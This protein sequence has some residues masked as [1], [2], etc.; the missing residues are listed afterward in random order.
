MEFIQVIYTGYYLFA[1]IIASFILKAF[2]KGTDVGKKLGTAMLFNLFMILAY[3]LNLQWEMDL[4]KSF[5]C[6][7]TFIMMDLMLLFYYD[8][9]LVFIDAHQKAKM[10]VKVLIVAYTFV[11]AVFMLINPFSEIALSYAHA[12]I[13]ESY[14]LK[15][16]PAMP[17]HIHVAFNI[18]IIVLTIVLLVL[19]CSDAP[20]I[21]SKR[22][23][24]PIFGMLLS[25]IVYIAYL[26]GL[27]PFDVDPTPLLYVVVGLSL[28]FY[29]FNY[30]PSVTMAITRNMILEYL[31]D[32][33]ILFDY[34]GHLVDYSAVMQ[35]LLPDVF[36][37]KGELTIE[38]F[39]SDCN[40]SG[41]GDA[42]HNQEFD[43]AH[44]EHGKT[45]IYQCQFGLLR[46]NENKLI[47]KLFVFHDETNAR[48]TFFELENSML[49]DTVTGLYNKQSFYTQIPQWNN[50]EYWPV[51][52]VVCNVDGLRAMNEAYGT[53][54]G[55][56]VMRQIAS[57]IR[58][59]VGEETFCAKMDNGD[60]VII[61]EKT[62]NAD[63][64]DIMEAVKGEVHDFYERMPV[65]V[66]FGIATKE[67]NEMT[68][69]KA[70]Q[71]A[72]TSMQNKKMLK[73]KSASSS[74]IDSL[75]QTLAES[76]DNTEEHVERTREMCGRLGRE[77]G[78]EDAMIG[79]LELL[80]VLHDIGKV[81]IPQHI[82]KKQ[83]KLTPE[84]RK[85]IEQHTVKGYRIAKSNPELSEV[86]EGILCH[87]EKWDGTGY[88][89]NLKAEEIPL[90]ARV[91]SAVESHDVMV[92]DRPYHKAMSEREA[93]AELRRCSGTQFDPH[94]V[95]VFTA[96]L[97]R[98]D[99]AKDDE[100]WE[101][102]AQEE[103]QV[104]TSED[105]ADKVELTAATV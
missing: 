60:I 49:F 4:I 36:L 81:A 24:G 18:I 29:T 21:F 1:L 46:D 102:K 13:G 27:I 30:L 38:E 19:K 7:F 79:K 77:L 31:N 66:E 32:P 63:A 64:G 75:R 82:I 104:A 71:I 10:W 86:A 51:S 101:A 44:E 72:R 41:M 33:I 69:E 42:E 16:V 67:D 15:Y 52:I 95:E 48:Q 20:K 54:Y 22:Y 87:H 39:I 99:L 105:N 17:F 84:E 92:N 100:K 85:I 37:K 98:E 83:G 23:Y 47:G 80:A 45:K 50:P 5:G 96:M 43:W 65:S 12:S 9:V 62:V 78:L 6:S 26:A 90:E 59:R 53:A 14:I 94:I 55:D 68:I 35:Q 61:L 93:I 11:D 97:E 8:Y 34:E 76:D 73:E 28:Y 74:I 3:T 88:P 40:F 57:Y 2:K 103:E 56:L 89:N 91:I 58:R 70:M 25:L